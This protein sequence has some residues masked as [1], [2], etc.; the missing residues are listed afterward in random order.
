MTTA[1]L[2]SWRSGKIRIRPSGQ[3]FL[4]AKLLDVKMPPS[5]VSLTCA[6]SGALFCYTPMSGL[7]MTLLRVSCS[8]L[9]LGLALFTRDSAAED[10]QQVLQEATRANIVFILTDDQDLHMDPLSYMPH[11]KD[12]LV[13]RG[14]SFNHHF[15]T[16]ALCCP[17]RVSM[18]TGKAA[19]KLVN[20]SYPRQKETLTVQ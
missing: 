11:L 8:L 6:L 4:T 9:F 10:G 2:V 17:S 5:N 3:A 18:W 16:V 20:I 1:S 15:C 19:R 14:L 12:H 13:D 7:D